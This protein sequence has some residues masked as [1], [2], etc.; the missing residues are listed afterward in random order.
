MNSKAKFL[1]TGILI[2]VSTSISAQ[3]KT[4]VLTSGDSRQVKIKTIMGITFNN[5]FLKDAVGTYG[6]AGSLTYIK[7]ETSKKINGKILTLGNGGGEK[8]KQNSY[9]IALNLPA[10]ANKG[11]YTLKTADDGSVIINPKGTKL[12]VEYAVNTV[13][14]SITANDGKKVSGEINGTFLLLNKLA[15]GQPIQLIFKSV[16]FYNCEIIEP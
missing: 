15:K 14:V 8:S 7:D 2:I 6:M 1:C 13:T 16:L 5:C 12:D 11:L 3:S 10:T 9:A 4:L